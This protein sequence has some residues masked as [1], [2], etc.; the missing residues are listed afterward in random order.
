MIWIPRRAAASGRGPAPE[1]KS[2]GVALERDAYYY[3]IAEFIDLI[4]QGKLESEVN[5]HENSLATMEIVDEVRRQLGVV[6][7]ADGVR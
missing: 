7:P 6:Y 4:E 1:R 2:V 5:S 3:E